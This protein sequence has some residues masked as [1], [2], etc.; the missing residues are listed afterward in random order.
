M[1]SLS[2]SADIPAST[3]LLGK[4][5]T[6]L[7]EDIEVGTDAIT[8]TL[9]A[10]TGYTG[11]SGDVAEQSGTYL[12]L[13]CTAVDGATITCEL[14]GGVHGPVNLD[15]DGLIIIRIT[16]TSQKVKV[17]ASMEGCDSVTKTYALTDLVLGE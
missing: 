14:I 8:G 1:T 7:Q 11:F 13:H 10:V 9:K 2:V 4:V 15:E 17:T 5:V 3:D 16:S 12:A 6:D